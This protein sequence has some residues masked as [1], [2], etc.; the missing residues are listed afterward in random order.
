MV[1]QRRIGEKI[2]KIFPYS[3]AIR[4]LNINFAAEKP[5]KRFAD[6]IF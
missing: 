3:L 1:Q 6:S 5:T 2:A 4:N